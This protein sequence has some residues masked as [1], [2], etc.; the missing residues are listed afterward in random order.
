MQAGRL[1][2]PGLG[3]FA[4]IRVFEIEVGV[5]GY[6]LSATLASRVRA[7]QHEPRIGQLLAGRIVA[8]EVRKQPGGGGV[9]AAVPEQISG[10][11]EIVIRSLGRGGP[12]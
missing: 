2:L 1:L 12:P 4:V 3:R 11:L 10:D 7:R 9:V 8:D 6:G 5:G